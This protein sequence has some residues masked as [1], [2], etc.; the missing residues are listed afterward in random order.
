MT[1]TIAMVAA[2]SLLVAACG[3]SQAPEG[4]TT[5]AVQATTST[6]GDSN[7]TVAETMTTTEPPAPT[8][9]LAYQTPPEGVIE[10]RLTDDLVLWDYPDDPQSVGM[11]GSE[12][13][14]V[15]T[16]SEGEYFAGDKELLREPEGVMSAEG[17]QGGVWQVGDYR[18]V[19]VNRLWPPDLPDTDVLWLTSYTGGTA[20][21]LTGYTPP[22]GDTFDLYDELV[23]ETRRL[24][25]GNFGLHADCRAGEDQLAAAL[26]SFEGPK[27]LPLIGWIV[28]RQALAFVP[29]E[30]L[31]GLV[32]GGCLAL[33][34]R[35]AN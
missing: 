4:V 8:S 27:P 5:T 31:E 10:V 35:P 25:V 15:L 3:G 14:F 26:I 1:R 12:V 32:L 23:L 19:E 7:P 2:L 29:V 33:Q 21:Q 20:D 28:D 6:I 9:T 24:G 30:D 22:P 11:R 17:W 16:H 13:V 34:P 18:Q